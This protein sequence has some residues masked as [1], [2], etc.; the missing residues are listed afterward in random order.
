MPVNTDP[1]DKI[2]QCFE[3]ISQIIMNGINSN[4]KQVIVGDFNAHING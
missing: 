4:K 1:H 2:I 3:G